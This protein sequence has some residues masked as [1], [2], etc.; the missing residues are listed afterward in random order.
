M[1]ILAFPLWGLASAVLLF[2]GI[3]LA[4]QTG[5]VRRRLAGLAFCQAGTYISFAWGWGVVS[6]H[7]VPA[8]TT[9]PT[10]TAA[11]WVVGDLHGP[12]FF[13]GLDSGSATLGRGAFGV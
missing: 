7:A 3:L 13:G 8:R 9:A 11:C 1:S 10:A 2:G 12:L 4:L 6:F 5:S